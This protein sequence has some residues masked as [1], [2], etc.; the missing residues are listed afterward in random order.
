MDFE[1]FIRKIPPFTK[2][3]MGT[4]LG[5]AVLTTL[6]VLSPYSLLLFWDKVFYNFQLWRLL[7]T[8]LFIGKISIAL[9]FQLFFM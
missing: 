4:A 9:I 8:Y 2:F 5:L 7:T 3:Y 6:G 1:E